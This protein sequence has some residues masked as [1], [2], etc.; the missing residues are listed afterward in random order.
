MEQKKEVGTKDS[1]LSTLHNTIFLY[2]FCLWLS[3]RFPF[4]L[5]YHVSI[6]FFFYHPG[7]FFSLLSLILPFF[8]LSS[9]SV[10]A[11]TQNNVK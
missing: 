10:S 6:L 5:S 4:P 3:F 9:V 1:S 7:R 2:R 8:C 11:M